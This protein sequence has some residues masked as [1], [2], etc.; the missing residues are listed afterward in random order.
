VT[1]ENDPVLVRLARRVVGGDR[2]ALGELL[3]EL[4]P[5]VVRTTRLIIGSGSSAAEDAA[6]DALLDVARGIETL[7]EPEAARAWAIRVATTRAIKVAQRERLTSLRRAELT[8]SEMAVE[9]E[10]ERLAA[11]KDAFDRLPPAMRATAVLRLYVGLSEAETAEA[12]DSSLGTVKSNL[13]DAR[14]RLSAT[15]VERGFAPAVPAR[16]KEE[17]A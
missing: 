11:L 4:E 2:G 14:R 17:T 8:G 7:R 15:L 10:D 1:V 12:L 9:P 3:R 13:H 5:V 16:Q 6:Q